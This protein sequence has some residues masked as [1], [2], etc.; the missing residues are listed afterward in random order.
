MPLDEL[1]SVQVFR[2]Q[3]LDF[4]HPMINNVVMFPGA[5]PY[6]NTGG[7]PIHGLDL[8]HTCYHDSVQMGSNDISSAGSPQ[9]K[10]QHAG[11]RSPHPPYG[12]ASTSH[13][14]QQPHHNESFSSAGMTSSMRNSQGHDLLNDTGDFNVAGGITDVRWTSPGLGTYDNYGGQASQSP[15][16]DN[17]EDPF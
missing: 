7:N 2:G 12:T 10:D 14:T 17:H 4:A 3:Q 1:Q 6:T 13:S 11:S 15:K 9:S 5:D 8:L 16:F